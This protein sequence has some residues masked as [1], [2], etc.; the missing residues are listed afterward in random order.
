M[1]MTQHQNMNTEVTY[2]IRRTVFVDRKRQ[3][4]RILEKEEKS[5]SVEEKRQRTFFIY[6]HEIIASQVV[7]RENPDSYSG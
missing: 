2:Q 7:F 4:N 5:Q 6:E 3:I 1:R